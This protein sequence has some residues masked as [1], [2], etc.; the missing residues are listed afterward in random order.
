MNSEPD[1]TRED[2]PTARPPSVTPEGEPLTPLIADVR[3]RPAK[4][5]TDA[6]G[7]LAEVYDPRWEF[8]EDPMVYAYLVTIRP[9]VTKGWI[10][11]RR[12]E[13]RLFFARGSVR[14]VLYDE[15][16]GSATR[17]MVNELFFDEHNRALLRIPTGVWH[18]V[19]NL[20]TEDSMMINHPSRPYDHGDPDKWDLPLDTPN[21]PYEL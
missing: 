1:A 3:I 8:T 21:I 7:T 6:R 20:G 2:E 14:V 12:H 16:E 19:T 9:G 11:H 15:R 5:Q 17:G 10:L 13:D 18:A 4:T